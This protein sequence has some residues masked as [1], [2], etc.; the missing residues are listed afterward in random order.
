MT[1]M[2]NSVRFLGAAD[3]ETVK[4]SATEVG[5]KISATMALALDQQHC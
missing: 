3:L 1:R 2:A 4:T 5:S